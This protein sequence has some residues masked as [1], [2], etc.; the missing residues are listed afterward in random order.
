V[1]RLLLEV[2]RA[3][4]EGEDEDK[5]ASVKRNRVV[6]SDVASPSKSTNK[7]GDEVLDRLSARAQHVLSPSTL[8]RR[9]WERVERTITTRIQTF[10][11]EKH[12]LQA[13]Q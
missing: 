12:I 7:G 5:S 3:E 9:G 1:Q 11:S 6:L 13:F 2:I 4:A 10:Q 8:A